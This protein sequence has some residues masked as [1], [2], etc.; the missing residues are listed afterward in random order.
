MS[1][2]SLVPFSFEELLTFFKYFDFLILYITLQILFLMQFLRGKWSQLK[3]FTL[4]KRNKIS[5]SP[6]DFLEHLLQE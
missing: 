2:L 4:G 6:K 3:D 1:F 5:N